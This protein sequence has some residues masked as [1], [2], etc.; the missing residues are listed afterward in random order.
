MKVE[1]IALKKG[2]KVELASAVRGVA[3]LAMHSRMTFFS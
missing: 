1:K 2:P 3:F